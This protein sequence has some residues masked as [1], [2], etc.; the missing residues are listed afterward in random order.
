MLPMSTPTV[1]ESPIHLEPVIAD[2][3]IDDLAGLSVETQTRLAAL[4]QR[5]SETPHQTFEPRH[6]RVRRRLRLHMRPH[7]GAARPAVA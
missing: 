6:P 7:V 1:I 2:P 5:A 3:F 4:T